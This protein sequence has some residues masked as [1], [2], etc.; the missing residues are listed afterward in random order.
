M[1]VEAVLVAEHALAWDAVAVCMSLSA[2]L[3]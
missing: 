3:V 1:R 2:V